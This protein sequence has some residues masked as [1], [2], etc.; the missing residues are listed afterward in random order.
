MDPALLAAATRLLATH[1]SQ[2]FTMDDLARAANVSRATLYR[3]AGSREAVL[4]R[5]SEVGLP[6]GDR[7]D[8]RQKILAAAR[9]VFGRAG[10]DGATIDD[11]A[12]EAGV[13][14]ATVYRRFG[15]KDGLVA[16]FLDEYSPRRFAREASAAPT[17]DLRRDLANLAG[18]VLTALRDDPSLFSL[19]LVETL[20]GSALISRV[21]ALS[22]Q[23]TVH[24]IGALLKP[25]ADAGRL[26]S[27]DV[28]AL[29]RGFG[30]LLMTHGLLGP[31]LGDSPVGDPEAT[32][33]AVTDLFLHG[34]L[35]GPEGR[36]PEGAKA[37][38]RGEKAK[39]RRRATGGP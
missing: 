38:R 18:K 17:G 14:L 28:S 37:A 13:G 4:D 8:T 20:R 22:T 21:R 25:H 32:A 10:F 19:V 7:S 9:T 15:D 33:R 5:L 1:G 26:R 39:A 36:P 35:R 12:T 29:A 16:A 27:H 24:S 30:G 2:G 11:V 31:L 6:V 23:R 3:Q 34:A